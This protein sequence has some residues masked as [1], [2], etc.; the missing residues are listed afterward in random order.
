MGKLTRAKAERLIDHLI[1]WLDAC[2]GDPDFERC[3]DT[4]IDD[5]PE[6]DTDNEPA[7]ED[8]PDH[9]GE[10]DSDAE[11]DSDDEPDGDAELSNVEPWSIVH[12]EADHG[13]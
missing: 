10:A 13:I 3:S 5:E 2:D 1:S 11:P 4:E 12:D 9:D 7:C 6:T 8:E